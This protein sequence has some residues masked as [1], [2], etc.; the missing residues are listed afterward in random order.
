M[1]CGRNNIHD[2]SKSFALI[3]LKMCRVKTL[4]CSMSSHMLAWSWQSVNRRYLP[5]RMLR[6]S[7]PQKASRRGSSPLTSSAAAG[8]SSGELGPR[9]RSSGALVQMGV[10]EDTPEACGR[11]GECVAVGGGEESPEGGLVEPGGG[12][13]MEGQWLEVGELAAD[14]EGVVDKSKAPAFPPMGELSESLRQCTGEDVRE[15]MERGGGEEN[16]RQ[17]LGDLLLSGSV[18]HVPWLVAKKSSRDLKQT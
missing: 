4:L 17:S 2:V 14:E 8:L 15:G 12:E 9:L 11:L 18:A 3:K 10:S 1:C 5:L 6:L 13:E 16:L 7:F